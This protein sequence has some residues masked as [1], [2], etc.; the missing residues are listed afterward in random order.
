MIYLERAP[1]PTLRPW[2]RSL[3]Y[4]RAPHVRHRHERVLPNGCIQIVINLAKD[5][6]TDCPSETTAVRLPPAIIVGARQCYEVIDTFDLAELV[7]IVIEPGGFAKFFRE[8]ADLFFEQSI[9]LDC[10]WPQFEIQPILE[11]RAPTAKLHTLETLL[12]ERAGKPI[13]RSRLVDGA[14]RFLNLP[15]ISIKDCARLV[16]ISDRRLSQLFKEEVGVSPKLWCRIQRFQTAVRNLHRGADIPWAEL[17]LQCGYYDQSHF[18]ND[19]RAFSGVNP[20]TYSALR[21]RWHN[22]LP[23]AS[24]DFSNRTVAR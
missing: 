16:G 20:M 17:A 11:A 6:L 23:L 8:R 7:G 2:L 9:A 24:S 19:F 1:G 3:W 15:G 12:Q 14:L 22:H 4:C 21:G 18:I 10:I 13:D 5:F